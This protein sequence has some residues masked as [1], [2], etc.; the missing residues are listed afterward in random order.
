MSFKNRTQRACSL[1]HDLSAFLKYD[2]SMF[3]GY[4]ISVF[5][6]KNLSVFL[7]YDLSMFLRRFDLSAFLG[8]NLGKKSLEHP[9]INL[10]HVL[11]MKLGGNLGKS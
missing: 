10:W 9:K 11:I 6:R 2:L 8:Y 5:L 7:R 3:L 1:T 4:D